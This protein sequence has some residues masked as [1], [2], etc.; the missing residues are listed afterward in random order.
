M[1]KG[2]WVYCPSPMLLCFQKPVL[3]YNFTL[4]L[5]CSVFGTISLSLPICP[6]AFFYFL[7][8][9]FSLSNYPNPVSKN[10]IRNLKPS[11]IDKLSLAGLCFC[12]NAVLTGVEIR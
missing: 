6:F 12:S 1:T 11:L 8:Y 10:L 3:S 5:T 9:F 2:L 4:F 7:F